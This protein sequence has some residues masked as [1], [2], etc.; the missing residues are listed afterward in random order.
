MPS[1]RA[2]GSGSSSSSSAGTSA[3][4]A[5]ASSSSTPANADAKANA[6]ANANVSVDEAVLAAAAAASREQGHAN[7]NFK[8]LRAALTMLQTEVEASLSQEAFDRAGAGKYRAN[9]LRQFHANVEE[10]LGEVLENQRVEAKLLRL[11][12]ALHAWPPSARAAPGPSS[13]P[14]FAK[15]AP[16]SRVK[17]HVLRVQRARKVVL[18]TE[19]AKVEED[20]RSRR[21]ELEAERAR[22][23][24]LRGDLNAAVG[25]AARVER[26]FEE[27]SS[28]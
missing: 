10:A 11:E 5:A 8:R 20:L 14:P 4:D 21:T 2:G 22:A 24:S 1:K 6:K 15:H 13:R 25:F 12:R 27:T 16:S 26:S 19:L 17:A 28:S 18:E 3:A 7:P 23:A 9:L